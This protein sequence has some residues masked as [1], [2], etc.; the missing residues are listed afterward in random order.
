M[1][2]HIGVCS[3][4]NFCRI[5]KSFDISLDLTFDIALRCQLEC[6]CIGTEGRL[7]AAVHSVLQVS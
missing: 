5:N 3:I 2:D 1:H 4:I 6:V 7:A